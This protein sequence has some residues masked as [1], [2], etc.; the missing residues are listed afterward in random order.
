MKFITGL[1]LNLDKLPKYTA[2][3]GDFVIDIGANN[4][5]ILENCCNS[6]N[7][8]FKVEVKD[9]INTILNNINNNND[10]LIVKHNQRHNVGRFY[11]NESISL[12]TLSRHA[13]HTLFK[14]MNWI[15]IDMVKGH[16][17]IL[18]EL[19]KDIYEPIVFKRYITEPDKIFNELLGFYAIDDTLNK[20]HIKKIFN[21]AIYG[22][23]FKTWLKEIDEDNIDLKTDEIHPFIQ[24][25]INECKELSNIIFK[26]NT[27][28]A[29]KMRQF[30]KEEK[31][32]WKVKNSVMSYFCQAI[33]NEILHLAY[34]FLIKKN[35]IT[36]RKNIE[37]E[38][39]GLCFKMP[40]NVTINDLDIIINELNEKILQE[41]T[42]NI[43]FKIK[44]YDNRHIHSDII[45]KTE[46]IIFN[47]ISLISNE[48]DDDDKTI[49]DTYNNKDT[50]INFHRDIDDVLCSEQYYNDKQEF[51]KQFFKLEFP[52]LYGRVLEGELIPIFYKKNDMPEL[53]GDFTPTYLIGTPKKHTQI[54]FYNIWR[55]DPDK[56]KYDKIV[57]EPNPA[58]H[59]DKHFNLFR[60]FKNDDPNVEPI[61]PEESYY[62]KLLKHLFSTEPECYNYFLALV[63][64][65][66]QKPWIKTK[67][68]VV[69]YTHAKGTG[70]DT[71]IQEGLQKIIGTEYFGKLNDID[72]IN[73]KF[74]LKLTNKLIIYGEEITANAKKVVDKLKEVITR[75]TCNLEKK[76]VDAV[77]VND[78]CNLFFTTN[79]KNSFKVEQGCRRLGI[80]ECNETKLPTEFFVKLYEELNDPVKIKQIFRF[81]KLYKQDKYKIGTEEVYNTK[82]KTELENESKQGYIQFLYKSVNAYANMSGISSTKLFEM[83]KEFCNK[84]YISSNYTIT[85]F[86]TAINKIL[87][88]FR[89]RKATGYV[90][91]FTNSLDILQTLFEYDVKYYRYINNLDADFIPSFKPEPEGINTDTEELEY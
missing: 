62:F 20:D 12:I 5:T 31:D 54:K 41:T 34:K 55:E 17:T 40:D 66:I 16:P 43:K 15:D 25:F 51:E 3:S 80:M 4:K 78:F 91:N 74:N 22:G 33:E 86:G 87:L 79:I 47:N 2:F 44:P 48:E 21:I 52:L 6:N 8:V 56:R 28:L 69:L 9:R 30:Y 39:D 19:F 72:D 37:L 57:F 61:N 83:S 88:K 46:D 60:G 82:C 65:I 73:T 64:H 36:P 35:V 32:E 59:N 10:K 76:G 11:P 89:V 14:F 67:V 29:D 18:Y 26:N 81:F 27:K 71:I 23:S 38:Y 53:V 49:I 68:A 70:K 63:S 77:M 75:T 42:L 84:N 13:K 58:L 50:G 1:T 24:E 90:Y 85:E 45:D 7:P